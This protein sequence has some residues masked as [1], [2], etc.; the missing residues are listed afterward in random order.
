MRRTN[1]F[2]RNALALGITSALAMVAPTLLHAEE[3]G[4][5]QIN[6]ASQNIGQAVRELAKDVGAQIVMP[7]ELGRAFQSPSLDGEYSLVQALDM[8]VEGSGLEYEFLSDKSVIIKKAAAE[9]G[10]GKDGSSEVTDDVDEEILVT[11]TRLKQGD[12]SA[13]VEVITSELIRSRGLSSAEEVIRSIPQ[14][15]SSINGA[16]NR[17]FS[18]LDVNLGGLGLGSSFANLRGLG[19]RNTLVLVNGRRIS[20]G[21]A[22]DGD[23]LANL[24]DIPAASIERVEVNLDGGSAVYGSDGIAG[25]INIILKDDY[26]GAQVSGIQEF[27]STDGDRQQVGGTFGHRWDSGGFTLNL[28]YT[29]TDQVD[30]VQAGNVTRD[31]SGLF[32]GNQN[33]NF[34]NV[35][36]G[37]YNT[38]AVQVRN[39]GPNLVLPG[40]DGTSYDLA[41]FRAPTLAEVFDGPNRID[42]TGTTED[43]SAS[44]TFNQELFGQL[45]LRGEV[46][47]TKSETSAR[48]RTIVAGSIVVPESNAFNEFNQNVLVAYN[49]PEA[50]TGGLPEPFQTNVGK[51]L[52]YNLGFDWDITDDWQLVV[53]YNYSESDNFGEQFGFGFVSRSS[54]DSA[55]ND[56]ERA[57]LQALRDQQLAVLVSSDPAVAVN[58]F[59][60]GSAQNLD[61]LNLFFFWDKQCS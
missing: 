5:Y 8:L 15:F 4:K 7:S 43:R 55:S 25:I 6:I 60:D 31:Y 11:G 1:I 49:L 10:Q 59:G 33:Y 41:D 61:A 22:G 40:I 48:G 34:L 9:E 45:N 17:D 13:R 58:L 57:R 53:D 51:Q 30:T 28:S 24:R 39:F 3:S 42:A 20:G 2:K 16:T 14:N 37:P 27:S 38:T 50:E 56:E 19:S 18:F 36:S 12:P 23:F 32:G 26:T 21:G 35:N 47:Y 44:I 54:V 46:F 29:E 52:R